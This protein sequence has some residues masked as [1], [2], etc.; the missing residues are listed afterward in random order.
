MSRRALTAALVAPLLVAAAVAACP[1][2]AAALTF[3]PCA[4][5]PGLD[6]ATLAVPLDRG[7]RVGGTITLRVER[8][9][10]DTV[11]AASAV[12][13]IAGGPGQ[14][15]LPLAEFI[16][17]TM[18]PA[19]AA[20]DLML[21]DQRGTGSSD[22]LTCPALAAP[23]T[24]SLGRL[25]ER[26]ALQIGPARGAYT[27]QESV[28]DI[29]SLRRAMGYERLVLYGT[30]YGTKVALQYAARYPAHVEAL[31]LDSVVPA[32]GPEPLALPSFHAIPAV[33]DE[34]CSNHACANITANPLRDL[35]RLTARLRRRPLRGSAF[36]GAGHRRAARVSESDLL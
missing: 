11:P 18:S 13:A 26:C 2:S 21:F 33:L 1:P 9:G 14:A 6:C 32:D 27:T 16:A 22:P 15:T 28:A 30:S 5:S 17:K 3:A 29:E 35:A 12:L 10:A 31:V 34:L 25:L 19:L 36:D 20:R 24:G 7:G 8:R 23:A 4:A